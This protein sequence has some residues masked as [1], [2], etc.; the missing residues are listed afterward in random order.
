MLMPWGL[1]MLGEFLPLP[2]L[3]GP[4]LRGQSKE[5][6]WVV[7]GFKILLFR[8]KETHKHQISGL[9]LLR[10]WRAPR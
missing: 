7:K 2:A 1:A 10:E 4:E 3:F 9:L 8:Q 6:P 5:F